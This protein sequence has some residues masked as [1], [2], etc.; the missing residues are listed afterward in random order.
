MRNKLSSIPPEH[1]LLTARGCIFDDMEYDSNIANMLKSAAKR[2]SNES[3]WLL[4]KLKDIPYFDHDSTMMPR[5]VELMSA[6]KSPWAQYYQGM[7]LYHSD[8]HGAADLVLESATAGFA[9]AMSELGYMIVDAREWVRKAAELKDPDGLYLMSKI[10]QNGQFELLSEAVRLGHIWATYELLDKFSDRISLPQTIRLIA[11]YALFSRAQNHH[12]SEIMIIS[13][14][15]DGILAHDE[16][17]E[18]AFMAGRELEGYSDFWGD[19]WHPNVEFIYFIRIYCTIIH[20]SRRAALQLIV[21]LR[22]ILGRDVSGMIGKMVYETR[23]DS[24]VW[25]NQ[26]NIR[27]RIVRRD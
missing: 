21:G 23:N 27:K 25:W 15:L 20:R 4:E 19:T 16:D 17:I 26:R 13:D 2:G 8:E 10:D 3:A 6:E 11:R 14:R 1:L 18:A 9:P 7:A 5:I 24:V 12:L 22:P